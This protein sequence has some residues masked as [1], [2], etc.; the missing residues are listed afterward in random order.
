MKETSERVQAGISRLSRWSLLM[1]LLLLLT[2]SVSVAAA[3]RPESVLDRYKK[4]GLEQAD[5]L[6]PVMYPAGARWRAL[7]YQRFLADAVA[8]YDG[9]LKMKIPIVLV[10]ADKD[11]AERAEPDA[12]HRMPHCFP[13]EG[14]VVIP[15][16]DGPHTV[17]LAT[18]QDLVKEA[19][20]LHETGHVFARALGIGNDNPS[21]GEL[22]ANVFMV[23]Y[24]RLGYPELAYIMKGPPEKPVPRYTSLADLDYLYNDVG[25]ENYSWFEHSLERLAYLAIQWK[26]FV[27]AIGMMKSS[28][29]AME[30]SWVSAEEIFWRLEKMRKGITQEAG[31]LAGPTTIERV[32]PAECGKRG[33][34]GEASV[35]AVRNDTGAALTVEPED[36]ESV[37][38][39]AGASYRVKGR[40][41]EILRLLPSSQCVVF[42]AAPRLAILTGE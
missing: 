6:V 22:V 3:Q 37:E 25:L 27:P 1:G 36:G 15:I 23:G 10:I 26:E 31:E 11:S 5:G 14:L 24:I 30:N 33:E 16:E 42:G 2:I 13:D 18:D 28:F 32:A 29:P 7:R 8:W 12:T 40:A 21:V 34:T 41:G 38:I 35:I 19:V 17:E 4:L 20:S 39:P 9:Q